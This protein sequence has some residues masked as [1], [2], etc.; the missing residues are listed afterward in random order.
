MNE[1][2]QDSATPFAGGGKDSHPSVLAVSTPIRTR[3]LALM[4]L[5]ALIV[6]ASA[7][8]DAS[9]RAALALSSTPTGTISL[10][11]GATQDLTLSLPTQPSSDVTVT[12][13][14]TDPTVFGLSTGGGATQDRVT[15][16]FTTSKWQTPQMVTVTGIGA[17]S[18]MLAR[19]VTGGGDSYMVQRVVVTSDDCAPGLDTTCHLGTVKSSSLAFSGEIETPGDIDWIGVNLKDR[20]T[21]EITVSGKAGDD[22]QHGT[23]VDPHLDNS[24]HL[25]RVHAPR[26]IAKAHLWILYRDIDNSNNDR[27]LHTIQD[28]PAGGAYTCYFAVTGNPTDGNSGVGTYTLSVQRLDLST[29]EDDCDLSPLSTCAVSVD[30]PPQG[31]I[32]E[33]NHDRDWFSVQLQSG[34]SYIITR[35]TSSFHGDG[36][37]ELGAIYNFAGNDLKHATQKPSESLSWIDFVAPATGQYW[38]E[39]RHQ[40]RR[41]AFWN[42]LGVYAV[43]V[44]ELPVDDVADDSSTTSA[45]GVGG[46]VSGVIGSSDDVDWHR[47]NLTANTE[48]VFDIAPHNGGKSDPCD[49]NSEE[50]ESY[51]RYGEPHCLLGFP[52]TTRVVFDGLY[53]SS[54]QQVKAGKEHE[55]Y[56]LRYAPTA[57][58]VHYIATTG[59]SSSL[60]PYTIKLA[61]ADNAVADD[62]PHDN[63]GATVDLT[64][65]QPG[66]AAVNITGATQYIQDEDWIRVKLSSNREYQFSLY[67]D[68]PTHD[69]NLDGIFQGDAGGG[70]FVTSIAGRPDTESGARSNQTNYCINAW[71]QEPDKDLR[72]RMWRQAEWDDNSQYC[73]VVAPDTGEYSFRLS[74]DHFQFGAYRIKVTAAAGPPDDH[75]ANSSTSA[76]VTTTSSLRARINYESDYDWVKVSM[77]ANTGYILKARKPGSSRTD[78]LRVDPQAVGTDGTPLEGERHHETSSNDACFEVGADGAYFVQVRGQVGGRYYHYVGPYVLT[79]STVAGGCP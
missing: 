57:T 18:A 15:L 50:A 12:L 19:Q 10:K 64:G 36:G 78:H 23:L 42:R 30:G 1:F 29:L 74:S 53:D 20:R 63:S 8:P 32:I 2:T 70:T 16:T 45:L 49:P 47:V 60:G 51:A 56:R 67:R 75:P 25:Q 22:V 62:Y 35:E 77:Q 61:T 69:F 38:I 71:W 66:G 54:G 48:Y 28:G 9:V 3:A 13:V 26:Q 46:T 65:L 76:V 79:L 33:R 58:G 68:Q 52:L 7:L 34:R 55:F 43:V 14:S 40:Y 5:F 24:C 73:K 17:G 37:A 21:Y 11:L 59:H 4:A 27:A 6:V 41:V 39:V 72:E 31:G 44:R